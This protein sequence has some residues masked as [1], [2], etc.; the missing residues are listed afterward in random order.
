MFLIL[1]VIILSILV[2]ELSSSLKAVRSF[3]QR[4]LSQNMFFVRWSQKNFT[5]RNVV[6]DEDAHAVLTD[7]GLSKEGVDALY[8]T[9]CHGMDQFCGESATFRVCFSSQAFWILR[10]F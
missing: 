6:L 10:F 7:F 4:P 2:L 1:Q 9:K 8:G 3:P 5:I